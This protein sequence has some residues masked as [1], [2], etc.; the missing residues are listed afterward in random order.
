MKFTDYDFKTLKKLQNIELMILKDFIKI[1]EENDLRYYIYAGTLIG[2]VRHGGFI[3][4]DDDV[5]VI[6][7]RKDY[8]KFKKIFLASHSEKYELLTHETYDDY[9]FLF[10]KIILKDTK[11]EEWWVDQVSFSVGINMDI[12]VLDYVSDN[13][14]ICFV[15]TKTT[16]ILRRLLAISSIKL[17]NY[18]FLTQ[19]ISNFIHAIFS[20][21][22]IKPI[23]IIKICSKLLNRFE[24]TKRVTDITTIKPHIYNVDDW[25]HGKKMKFEEIEVNVPE[26]YHNILKE[27]YGDYMELPPEDKRYNHITEELDFGNY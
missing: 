10:S 19:F 18:P 5:D 16:R 4:W 2:V 12:F 17:I 21:L 23:N 24:N 27:I 22:R 6:M 9:F 15:Q 14:V 7:F 8:E 11:F 25:G 26:N 20:F 1:C 13:N 3:P